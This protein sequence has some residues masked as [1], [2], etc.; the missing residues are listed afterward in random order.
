VCFGRCDVGLVVCGGLSFRSNSAGEKAAD[1]GNR[2][3]V[4][5]ELQSVFL[6]QSAFASY[7]KQQMQNLVPSFDR[8]IG[9]PK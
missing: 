1:T 4:S 6:C 3:G 9:Q 5:G 8:S 2:A 7:R